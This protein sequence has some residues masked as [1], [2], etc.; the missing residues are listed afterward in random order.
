MD[1]IVKAELLTELKDNLQITWEDDV[2]DRSL[3]R[4]IT[5]SKNVLN[6]LCNGEL[7]YAAGSTERELLLER[8]RYMWNN[9]T[10]SF[11]ENYRKDLQRLSMKYAVKKFKEKEADSSE[12]TTS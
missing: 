11:R 5:S 2:T 8:C 6:E 3:V 12:Q 1:E 7:E 9:A 10:D 4:F